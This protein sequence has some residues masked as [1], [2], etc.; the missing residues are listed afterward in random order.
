MG[1]SVARTRTCLEET[2]VRVKLDRTGRVVKQLAADDIVK[3]S[4]QTET[5][6]VQKML[7]CDLVINLILEIERFRTFGEL[8]YYH[9]T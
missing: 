4:S 3:F 5:T 6:I 1:R 8:S 2:C 9:A 7:I